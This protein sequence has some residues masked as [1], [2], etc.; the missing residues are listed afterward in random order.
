[1]YRMFFSI[2]ALLRAPRDE[3]EMA[4]AFKKFTIVL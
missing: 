2:Q 4:Y 1:M 3:Q